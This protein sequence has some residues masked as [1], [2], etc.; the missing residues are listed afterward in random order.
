MKG[1]IGVY[2][3][4]KIPHFLRDSIQK[5]VINGKYL[6][7]SSFVREAVKEKLDREGLLGL[8]TQSE[9]NDNFGREKLCNQ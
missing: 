5:A 6:N 8:T 1:N 3:G 2:V 4:S 7:A 9:G